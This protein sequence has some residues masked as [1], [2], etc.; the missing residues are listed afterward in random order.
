MDLFLWIDGSPMPVSRLTRS[1]GN[2]R[3]KVF[4]NRNYQSGYPTYIVIDREMVVQNADLW[5]F[6]PQFVIDLL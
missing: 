6:D 1:S 4:D 2:S 3:W 5:P